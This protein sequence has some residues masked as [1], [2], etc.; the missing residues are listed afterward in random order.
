M[1]TTTQGTRFV[2][3]NLLILMS[4]EQAPWAIG[5]LGRAPVQTPHLDRLAARGTTFTQAYSNSPICV[6]ARAVLQT[7][8]YVHQIG[9]WDSAQ[10][11]RGTP[12]GW[13]HTIRDHGAT[14]VSVGKLH[15]RSSDDDNGFAPELLPLHVKDGQGWLPGLLRRPLGRFPAAAELASQVGPGR[16]GYHDYDRQV[17]ARAAAWLRDEAP[18]ERPW[19]LLASFVSPHFPLVAPPEFYRLY[20]D[21]EIPPP[22]PV[23]ALDHPALAQL[24]GFFDYGRSFTEE[25]ARR[26]RVAYYGLVSFLDALAGQVLAGLEAGGQAE[27]T[28]VLFLS[29]HGEMLGNK[30]LWTKQVMFEESLGIPMI[31]AGPD[32]PRGRKV[33]TPV[34]LVD[35]APTALRAVLGHDGASGA[36]SALQDLASGEAQPERPLFAEYHDGGSPTGIFAYRRGRWKLVHYEGYRPQLFD[37]EADP[38]ETIDLGTSPAHARIREDLTAAL[39]RLAD[40]TAVTARAFA[41]QDR[42]IRHYGGRAAVEAMAA[43]LNFG[44]TPPT[45]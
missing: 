31:L 41:D 4:D 18:K 43:R 17:A 5:C 32:V 28:S 30:G 36:G 23:A 11:Y 35:V 26:A 25:S 15:F 3:G 42:L 2:P 45:G 12:R 33:A 8:R 1:A 27:R 9:C 40:P 20:E 24:V 34:S 38:G 44:H 10:P 29:D 37:L 14:A 19:A 6:P 39:T 7:G 16:S 13:A 21:T 22:T